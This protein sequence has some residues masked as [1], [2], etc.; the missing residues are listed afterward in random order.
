[1]AP[2]DGGDGVG[3]GGGQP[4]PRG[5]DPRTA[6]AGKRSHDF[7]SSHLIT[8]PFLFLFYFC[9]RGYLWPVPLDLLLRFPCVFS[10]DTHTLDLRLP[11]DGVAHSVDSKTF[12]LQE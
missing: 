5:G 6:A 1:M 3:E 7:S 10:L 4:I 9:L 8:F 11:W 2:A 12:G